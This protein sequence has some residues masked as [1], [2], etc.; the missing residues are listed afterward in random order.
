[1]RS[2]LPCTASMACMPPECTA[3]GP[4]AGSLCANALLTR[5]ARR[6]QQTRASWVHA[7]RHCDPEVPK[8]TVHQEPPHVQTPHIRSLLQPCI[9]PTACCLGLTLA[10]LGWVCR[11][12]VRRCGNLHYCHSTAVVALVEG[13]LV[14]IPLEPLVSTHFSCAKNWLLANS[15]QCSL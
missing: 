2:Q 13:N 14:Q 1:M 7:S 12:A 15:V 8:H 4:A 3:S 11:T 10:S 9:Q 5:V 6:R